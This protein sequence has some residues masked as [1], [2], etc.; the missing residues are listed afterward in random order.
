[1]PVGADSADWPRTHPLRW[2]AGQWDEES[3]GHLDKVIAEGAR[4]ELLAQLCLV[5]WWR[6]TGGVTQ[7]LR[8]AGITDAADEKFSFGINTERAMLFYTNDETRRLY[9]E[10]LEKLVTRR[11][12]VT[13]TLYR[14]DPTI[15]G[16]ELMNEAQA[17]TGR[18]AERRA[19][20]SEMSD[21]LRSLDPNHII[22][23][24]DWGYRTAAE[25]REWLADHALP[26]IDYAD[27]HNYPKPDSNSFVTSPTAL[28]EFLENRAA[29][30]FS[31]GKPLVLGE[32]G[33]GP[34]GYNGFSQ[35]DW[36][37]AFFE[38]NLSAGSDGAMFWIFTPD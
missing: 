15:F 33:I 12:T 7:Y 20:I 38:S 8:W 5:N 37:R 29:A 26:N 3:L 10:H 31:L 28:R 30:A 9:R 16:W 21:Y 35:L 6:D 13:G 36:Y 32:F 27:V 17:V 18:W 19:W 1:G 24:G 4:H 14:D 23:P 34:E 22:T 11:N 25:R 2:A